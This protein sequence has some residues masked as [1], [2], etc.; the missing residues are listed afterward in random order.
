MIEKAGKEN[1]SRQ[2]QAESARGTPDLFLEGL[3]LFAA[4]LELLKGDFPLQVLGYLCTKTRHFAQLRPN[5][6]RI[7][8]L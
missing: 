1:R 7:L 4:S 8:I 6:P 5:H 2:G 3:A